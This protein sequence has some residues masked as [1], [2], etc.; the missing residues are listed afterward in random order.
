MDG[1]KSPFE[2]RCCRTNAARFASK[3]S[4]ASLCLLLGVLS[5]VLLTVN[6]Q[7]AAWGGEASAGTV[8][9]PLRVAFSGSMFVDV[10]EN[11]ASAAVRVWAQMLSKEH[12][13]PVDPTVRILRGQKEIAT[14]LH[15]QTIDVITLTTDE[16]W[17]L[18]NEVSF[19]SPVFGARKGC[20][21]EQ[22]V[23]LVHR[24][25]NI[26]RLTDLRG[27]SLLV[28][29]NPRTS[30]ACPWLETV[31]GQDGENGLAGF[32][33][34]V[35]E[36]SKL[37]RAILP[38]FFRQSDACLVTRQGFETAAELN[39]QVGKQLRVSAASEELVPV[40]FCF[41]DDYHTTLRQRLLAEIAHVNLSP[42]GQQ[43]MTLFQCDALVEKPESTMGNAF[44]LLAT[45]QTL[46]SGANGRTDMAQHLKPGHKGGQD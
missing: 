12:D 7:R 37:T 43:F 23:L 44:D 1:D 16:Y 9:A 21:T 42:A 27:R 28:F 19:G 3:A 45:H 6:F 39:P 25:S 11:D 10:N 18:T 15:A 4:K 24:D 13:I 35:A 36:F 38:V 46:R 14:A 17:T 20:L 32:F 34:R 31:L 29:H 40:V 8:E 26:Q 2:L 33:S 5:F 22:Y 30:L 41:R